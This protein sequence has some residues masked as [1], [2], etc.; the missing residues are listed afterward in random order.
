MLC[1]ELCCVK[2]LHKA[3]NTVYSTDNKSLERDA[4]TCRCRR[5]QQ[6]HKMILAV[7]VITTHRH[8]QCSTC[9]SSRS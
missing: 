9:S 8:A 5:W 3:C 6:M 7:R 2:W 1:S 4:A